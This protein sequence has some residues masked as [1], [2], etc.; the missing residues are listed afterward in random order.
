VVMCCTGGDVVSKRGEAKRC[1][2]E[3]KIC[4]KA[5]REGRGIHAQ[6]TKFE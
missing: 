3:V 2:V 6:S 1:P 5:R 4:K